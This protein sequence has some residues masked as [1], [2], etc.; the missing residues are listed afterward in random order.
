M[1]IDNGLLS[2]NGLFLF[3]F[4]VLSFCFLSFPLTILLVEHN[5]LSLHFVAI[6]SL[7]IFFRY[8]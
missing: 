2:N 4:Y 3:L 1:F 6:H 7:R 8:T 5:P